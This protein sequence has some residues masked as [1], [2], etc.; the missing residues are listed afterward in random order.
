MALYIDNLVSEGKVDLLA[1]RSQVAV[2]VTAAGTLTLTSSS[3]FVQFFTGSTSGQIVKMPDATTLLAGWMYQFWNESTQNVTIQDNS[4]AAIAILGATQRMKIV[5]QAAGSAAGTWSYEIVNKNPVAD[6]FLT[7]YPGTGL[8]VNYLGGIVRFNAVSTAVAGGTIALPASTTGGWL[9]VDID[10]VVKATATLPVNAIPLY[11]FTTS[12]T[13]VTV[14]TDQREHV[15]QNLVW[16]VL[17]DIVGQT[18]GQ[19]KSAGTLEKYARADHVHG[20]TEVLKKSGVVAAGT[21][22]G[23]PKTA[24]VTFTTAFPNTSYSIIIT[25]LDSRVWTY[26]SKATTGFTISTNA[27]QALTGEVSWQA[28][29][30]GETT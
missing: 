25:G 30:N 7:T 2:N 20:N 5:L 29:A 3:Q 11:Q 16:G 17:A 4:G 10:G 1:L 18:S 21:F 14:L 9:Y 19:T 12:G 22:T 27:N 15:D 23:N 8:S 28:I 24:A 6:E 13:A 26:S